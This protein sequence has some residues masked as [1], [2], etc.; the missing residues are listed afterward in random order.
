[1]C[2]DPKKVLG[3][4]LLEVQRRSDSNVTRRAS[5]HGDERYRDEETPRR[6]IEV[7]GSTEEDERQN[8]GRLIENLVDDNEW[9][10]NS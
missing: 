10:R 5:D 2:A 1:V 9:A 7:E 6:A 4:L 3:L 8:D